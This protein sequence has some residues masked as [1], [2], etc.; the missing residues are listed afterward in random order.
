MKGTGLF[1]FVGVAQG[2]FV[3]TG[4]FSSSSC[5]DNNLPSDYALGKVT[6]WGVDGE[7]RLPR[8]CSSLTPGPHQHW[9]HR[10][11]ELLHLGGETYSYRTCGC[12]DAGCLTCDPSC[13]NITMQRSKPTCIDTPEIGGG[14]WGS[15]AF[16]VA[17]TLP[18]EPTSGNAGPFDDGVLLDSCDYPG[19]ETV[20]FVWHPYRCVR[21]QRAAQGAHTEPLPQYQILN[22]SKYIRPDGMPGVRVTKILATHLGDLPDASCVDGTPMVDADI[23]DLELDSYQCAYDAGPF[24]YSKVKW[25]GGL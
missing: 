17:S 6:W 2:L 15:Q 1:T 21:L 12:S 20:H 18:S 14:S 23:K 7:D 11:E 8:V 4:T 9:A 5:A 24:R 25:A 16:S 3:Q 13:S 19:N 10:I 22:A